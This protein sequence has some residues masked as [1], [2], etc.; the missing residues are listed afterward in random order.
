MEE[1]SVVEQLIEILENIIVLGESMTILVV[2]PRHGAGEME[3]KHLQR[4]AGMIIS[5]CKE[6]EGRIRALTN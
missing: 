6:A 3:P 2:A 1:T 5:Q 4:I